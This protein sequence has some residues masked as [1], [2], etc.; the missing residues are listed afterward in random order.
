MNYLDDLKYLSNH[1]RQYI[2]KILK[3][4]CA[5]KEYDLMDIE[6]YESRYIFIIKDAD[7]IEKLKLLVS[8]VYEDSGA[9]TS[10]RDSDNNP[11]NIYMKMMKTL[12]I[13]MERT[14]IIGLQSKVIQKIKLIN[15][16]QTIYN[17]RLLL[18]LE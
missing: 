7:K 13:C 18:I 8:V 12:T 11:I 1:Q 17:R 10:F 4:N 6:I 5:T 3:D 2:N 16:M 14:F 15:L 9:F